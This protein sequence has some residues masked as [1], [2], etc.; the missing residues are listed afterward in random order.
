MLNLQHRPLFNGATGRYTTTMLFFLLACTANTPDSGQ[1][2]AID[3]HHCAVDGWSDGIRE[4]DADGPDTQ[5]HIEAHFDGQRIWQAWNRPNDNSNFDIWARI[6]GCDGQPITDP[7][8]VSDSTENELDPVIAFTEGHALIAWIAS[9]SGGLAVRYRILDTDGV[10]TTGVFDL[11]AS[12]NGVP[13]TG[14]ATLPV[15][16][17]VG[18]HFVMAGSWGHDDATAFQ[19]FTVEIGVDGS[20]LGDA[21]D[22]ELD[23]ENG[24]TMVDMT[25]HSD[26]IHLTWQEDATDTP[27]PSAWHAPLGDPAVLLG[28]PGARP[29]LAASTAGVWHAWD[30]NAGTVYVQSPGGNPVALDLGAGFHH[31]PRLAVADDTVVALVMEMDS[32]IYNRLRLVTLDENGVTEDIPLS[33]T[34]APSVY[35]A[36]VVL[37]DASHAVVAWQEGEN[38]AFRAFTEWVSW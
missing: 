14:N 6:V 18:D 3:Q 13:V 37:V 36:S 23:T 29:A 5:I 38:P 34:A 12:R 16:S 8:E 15:V 24:Q 27:D 33:A 2:T 17:T 31:S 19:A 25:V 35:E 10:P 9:V 30:D 21:T 22:A 1:D 32:G 26:V 4:P 20:I 11:Q 28:T 7:F